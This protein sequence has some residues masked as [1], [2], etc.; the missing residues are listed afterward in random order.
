MFVEARKPAVMT[1][2]ETLFKIESQTIYAG[3]RAKSKQAPTQGARVRNELDNN[4]PLLRPDQRNLAETLS[5]PRKSR[6][7]HLQSLLVSMGSQVTK[8]LEERTARFPA[9]LVRLEGYTEAISNLSA[10]DCRDSE[11]FAG[12]SRE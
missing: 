4:P 10:V 5:R 9:V 12:P 2:S 1:A 8:T 11:E 6:A 7:K 3:S